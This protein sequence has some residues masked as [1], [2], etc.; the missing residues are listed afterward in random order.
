MT[1]DRQARTSAARPGSRDVDISTP[2]VTRAERSII[3]S[4]TS[5]VCPGRH[6]PTAAS[7]SALITCA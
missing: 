2:V 5:S 3:A 7:I 6:F 4:V 1:V